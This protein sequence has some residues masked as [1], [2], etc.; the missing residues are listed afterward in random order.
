MAWSAV[1]ICSVLGERASPIRPICGIPQGCPCAGD[2]LSSVIDPWD[3]H[4]QITNP[5]ISKW[6]FVDDRTLGVPLGPNSENLL[7]DALEATT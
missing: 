5:H 7:E 2:T 1:R 3:S 4:I 6:A